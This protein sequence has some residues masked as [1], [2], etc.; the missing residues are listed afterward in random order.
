[1]IKKNYPNNSKS[2]KGKW[3]I[4][5]KLF[6]LSPLLFLILFYLLEPQRKL[7]NAKDICGKWWMGQLETKIAYKKLVLREEGDLLEYCV[8]FR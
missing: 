3:L 6:F 8:H 7:F 4:N 1:M 5:K 2:Q